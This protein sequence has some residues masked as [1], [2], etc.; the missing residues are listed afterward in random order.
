M[1]ATGDWPRVR[2]WLGAL[3]LRYGVNPVVFAA[4]Y[5]GSI[6]VSLA[7][8]AWAARNHRLGLAT[9]APV[10]LACL[11]FSSASL[12]V[13]IVGRNLPLAAYVILI[14]VLGYGLFAAARK[15][16]PAPRR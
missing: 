5:L 11:S 15:T 10:A 2:G 4:L 16:G 7:A 14:L 3:A 1:A 9:R 6:P 12:Y 8:V 13:L